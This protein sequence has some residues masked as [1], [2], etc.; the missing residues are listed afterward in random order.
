MLVDGKQ[1]NELIDSIKDWM[2]RIESNIGRKIKEEDI[3]I[4]LIVEL[5]ELMNNNESKF[6]FWKKN[7]KDNKEQSLEEFADCL[8]FLLMYF[9]CKDSNITSKVTLE[10]PTLQDINY[11][12]NCI[13]KHQSSFTKLMYL[14][15]LGSL[16]G[17]TWEEVYEAT[18]NKIEII[19]KRI[20]DNY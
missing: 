4:P 17:F 12:I 3:N 16:L 11:C 5:G 10:G 20:D 9:V 7:C 14:F 8:N 18:K 13:I 1:L 19:N 15:S 2:I 6:K